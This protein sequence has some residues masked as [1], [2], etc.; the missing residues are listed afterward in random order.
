ENPWIES[1][2]CT[3]RY[4]AL[5]NSIRQYY[6]D[7]YPLTATA[8]ADARL[9][10]GGGGV[11]RICHEPRVSAAVLEQMLAPFR[12]KNLTLL[13]EHKPV[14]AQTQGDRVLSV[15]FHDSTSNSEVTITADYFLDA[16]ELG[17]LLPMTGTEYV[18]GA[19]SQA[20]TS[21]PHAVAGSPQ[22]ENVQ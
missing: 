16:T 15:T 21:E 1:F 9:N 4:R 19:E 2:G 18:S 13:L 22:P 7:H 20:Q 12:G 10:P 14:R 8:R 17:D 6:R 11:S 3:R 5:R